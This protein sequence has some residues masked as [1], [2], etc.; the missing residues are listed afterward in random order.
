MV[1]WRTPMYVVQK[2]G[3]QEIWMRSDRMNSEVP[4]QNHKGLDG[5]EVDQWA[6]SMQLSPLKHL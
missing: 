4:W 6:S 1:A 2:P 5:C 3:P